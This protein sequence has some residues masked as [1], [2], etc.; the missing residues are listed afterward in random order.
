[1]DCYAYL[2][3]DFGAFAM[4]NS[5]LACAACASP[6]ST[7]MADCLCHQARSVQLHWQARLAG[8]WR[9]LST[10]ARDRVF[11]ADRPTALDVDAL[12]PHMQRDLH[13]HEGVDSRLLGKNGPRQYAHYRD[14]LSGRLPF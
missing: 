3:S 14:T 11:S 8:W 6:L 13:L 4:N 7:D 12:S 9:R 2:K 5:P 10:A 1:M